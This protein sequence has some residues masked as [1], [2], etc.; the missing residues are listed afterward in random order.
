MSNLKSLEERVRFLEEIALFLCSA[1]RALSALWSILAELSASLGVSEDR[2]LKHF[3]DLVRV[4]SARLL[5]TAGDKCPS[6][7]AH[8]GE[9]FSGSDML[10]QLPPPIFHPKL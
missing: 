2:F 8:L 6:L 9:S 1:R 7:S 5:E 3:Q 10:A 4:H